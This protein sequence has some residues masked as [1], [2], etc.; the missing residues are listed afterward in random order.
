MYSLRPYQQEA[1]DATLVWVRKS[2]DA[3]LIESATGS[4]KSLMVAALAE[5]LHALS[6]GKHVMCL[7][8]NSDLVMQNREKYLA[9]GNPASIYSASAGGQCLRHP[10]VFG[11]PG[12]VKKAAARIGAKFCAVIVDEAHGITQPCALSST[13]CVKETRSCALLDCLL[14]LIG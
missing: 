14:H 4:G 1:V 10:V 12:T 6:N 2:S 13:R 11:T 7:A 8:P 5:K 3:C 9:T